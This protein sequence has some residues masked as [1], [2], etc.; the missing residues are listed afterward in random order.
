MRS[1]AEVDVT[2]AAAARRS[3][4]EYAPD[5]IVHAAILNDFGRLEREGWAAYVGATGNLVATG[6]PVVL[7]STDW[8]FDGRRGGY[9]KDAPPNPVNRYDTS[10]DASATAAALG[11]ELP[12][13]DTQ[14]RRLERSLT[15]MT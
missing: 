11:V 7:V 13:L 15:C 3:V 9:A 6:V 8:V 14:L 12:D 2:D 5:A 4:A 1:H 10:L